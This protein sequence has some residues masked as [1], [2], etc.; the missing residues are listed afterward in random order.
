MGSLP[1]IYSLGAGRLLALP[2]DGRQKEEF[3]LTAAQS[4]FAVALLLK[5]RFGLR[6]AFILLGLFLGQFATAFV[7]QHDE[8][9]TITTLTAFAWFYMAAAAGLFFINRKVLI[10]LA[11]FGVRVPAR[12]FKESE[13]AD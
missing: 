6:S 2:L 13:S 11:R 4:L 12:N 1:I 7:L 8:A 3:F 10:D 9:R 5:L